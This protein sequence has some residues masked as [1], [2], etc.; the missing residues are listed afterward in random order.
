MTDGIVSSAGE[1][2][3][4]ALF[5]DFDGTLVEIAPLP[6][7]VKLDRRMPAALD[8]LR[9]SLGGA[10]ALVS[11]R[12]IDFLDEVLA[13][14]RFDIAGLHGAQIRMDGEIR[15]QLDVPDSMREATRDLVRF[16]NSNVGVIVEDKRISV[17]LHW[18][19]APHLQD[20]AL[21]MMRAIALRM[22][23]GVRLQEGK[24][25]A[26]LVPAGAS[27][28]EAIAWLMSHPPY[29]GRKPVFIGDDVTDEA[30][31]EAVNAMGG[32][33]IR[34]GEGETCAARR[35]ASPTELRSIILAAAETGSLT[36]S[37]FS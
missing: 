15:S 27:K 10:L 11:G 1:Q 37:S 34:I 29:A 7:A 23:P 18:R 30:G 4:I 26:E 35:L 21:E 28:G 3:G 2:P 20:E 25:V 5:L 14:H 12:P 31:F 6:D 19:M 33:S 9:S 22:G 17:A 32:L 13:P 24:A 16:A 8:A 36:D